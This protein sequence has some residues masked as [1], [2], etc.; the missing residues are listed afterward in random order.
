MIGKTWRLGLVVLAGLLG[1]CSELTPPNPRVDVELLPEKQVT[2]KDKGSYQVGTIRLKGTDISGSLPVNISISN[3]PEGIRLESPTEVTVGNTTVERKLVLEIDPDKLLGNSNSI[4]KSLEVQIQPKDLRPTVK[5]LTLRIKRQDQS[6]GGQPGGGGTGTLTLSLDSSSLSIS[7]GG[8]G[9]LYV[10][11]SSTGVSGEVEFYLSPDSSKVKMDPATATIA[12]GQAKE[13]LTLN[14]PSD[15]P[16][17]SYSLNVGVRSKGDP[18]IKDEKPLTVNV[19]SLE[20]SLS[21]E[22]GYAYAGNEI[23]GKLSLKV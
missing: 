4:E 1:A 13:V 10:A 16:G 20:A 14:V 19:P 23:G 8:A 11:V 22:R 15:T 9:K 12:S 17:G 3:P 6:G 7:P 18:K 2:V 21:L 5:D